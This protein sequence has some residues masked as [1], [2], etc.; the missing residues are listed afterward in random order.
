MAKNIN[1]RIILKH[2]TEANW[3]KAIN[4]I[5]NKG[6][7]II[8]DIDENFNYERVKI[9]DGVN[10]ATQLPFINDNYLAKDN[11]IEYTPVNDYNPA[12]KKYVDDNVENVKNN[13]S[14]NNLQDKPFE[15][16]PVADF[17]VHSTLDTPDVNICELNTPI[18]I[19]DLSEYNISYVTPDVLFDTWTE[20]NTYYPQCNLIYRLSVYSSA[21]GKVIT[22]DFIVNNSVRYTLKMLDNK[23]FKFKYSNQYELVVIK[24]TSVLNEESLALY[25]T[26]G[27][28]FILLK[29]GSATYVYIKGGIVHSNT[30]NERHVNSSIARKTWVN[31][32]LEAKQD[33]S[34]LVTE[35]TSESTDIQYPS[36]TAVKDYFDNNTV[37]KTAPI[38]SVEET[39]Y[40]YI[41]RI[42]LLD[43]ESRV[44]YAIKVPDTNKTFLSQL[45]VPCE[46]GTQRVVVYAS[47]MFYINHHNGNSAN[48]YINDSYYYYYIDYSDISTAD[49]VVVT[50]VFEY[51]PCGNNDE[52]TPTTD[53]SPA[54]KKYVDDAVSAIDV[55]ADWSVNDPTDKAYIQNRTHYDNTTL[56][57]IFDEQ[58][59][60]GFIETEEPIWYPSANEQIIEFA[61]HVKPTIPLYV[62]SINTNTKPEKNKQ[63]VVTWDGVS[64]TLNCNYYY[65][66]TTGIIYLGNENYISM[67]PGGDVPFTIIITSTSVYLATE[68]T[69]TSHTVSISEKITELHKLDNKYLN[70]WGDVSEE[71]NVIFDE[72]L[73]VPEGSVEI[74]DFMSA[75]L[76]VGDIYKI[77]F[78]DVEYECIAKRDKYNGVYIGCQDL[79]NHWT[80]D[81]TIKSSEPFFIATYSPDNW[82]TFRVAESGLYAIKI[83]H[84][85]KI[86][87]TNQINKEYIPN[88][89][90]W[91]Q[92]E[93]KKS[94]YIQ[95]RTHWSEYTK[96]VDDQVVVK[97]D[98][99]NIYPT[100]PLIAGKT[101]RV[102]FNNN[103][104]ICTARAWNGGDEDTILIGNGTIYGDGDI[105]NN[106]PFSCGYY[107]IDTMYLVTTSNGTNSLVIYD[108]EETVHQLDEKYIPDSIARTNDIIQSDWN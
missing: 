42:N 107:D 25:P 104:Y 86:N 39:D 65:S 72:T 90:D 35:I 12:T 82:S 6:E 91:N 80:F 73:S 77:S 26:N 53:Y 44:L 75:M 78:N 66:T 76:K 10:N 92:N 17:I 97:Y 98:H 21:F 105:G 33:A 30:I 18:L 83:L 89:S 20:Q 85:K 103:E 28:Y 49:N 62:T 46:D 99:A 58:V 88:T 108:T 34:N 101:Y 87:N 16:M 41:Q 55:Q 50:K 32:Q 63:Y 68:S 54:T 47:N 40:T 100:R 2:D 71:I 36:A 8:Y 57:P 29:A 3:N 69:D 7:V 51:L 27:V 15:D 22:T 61:E 43:L 102:L 24:D 106:E 45:I 37:L 38:Y 48:L 94:G 14:W 19:Q 52:Y 81:E 93:E 60:E 84:I 70:I 1:T 5:P 4:F 56:S 95:N 23:N 31:T 64:Y 67:L 74:E 79:S 59:V 13:I 9:G 96:I 11:I